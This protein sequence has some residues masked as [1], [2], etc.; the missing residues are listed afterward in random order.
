MA[1]GEQYASIEAVLEER[2]TRQEAEP[3]SPPAEE[4]ETEQETETV[5]AAPEGAPVAEEPES[6]TQTDEVVDGEPEAANPESEEPEQPEPE[7]VIAAP[8][9]WDTEGKA[10]FAKLPK[11]AQKAVATYEKQRTAA[12]ARKMNEVSQVTKAA[13]AKQEQLDARMRSVE[14]FVSEADR[15]IAEYEGI[16]WQMEIAEATTPE[17]RER[18]LWHQAR[19]N[20]LKQA[21][22]DAEKS[23]DEAQATEHREF[24]EREAG[25]LARINPQLDVKTPEGAKRVAQVYAFLAKVPGMDENTL[26]WMPGAAVD[27]AH[28]AMRWRMQQAKAKAAASSKPAPQKPPAGPTT[29]PVT[30]PSG[31]SSNSRLAQLE[32]KE[33]LSESEFLEKQRLKRKAKR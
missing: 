12:V 17:D 19:Y 28:D 5:E 1:D 23:L 9:F 11:E 13:Q 33:T 26:N 20:S 32:K 29:A 31:T 25:N 7:E 22:A 10:E 6:V 24:I 30:S 3:A 18:V 4:P 8:D 14:N 16:D 2:R 21:K 27:L 15:A